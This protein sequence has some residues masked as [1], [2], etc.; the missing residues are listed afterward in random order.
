MVIP[1]LGYYLN[2]TLSLEMKSVGYVLA[3]TSLLGFS[4]S[5]YGGHF[6]DKY[7]YKNSMILAHMIRF[8]SFLLIAI[9]IEVKFLVVFLLIL[10]TLGN[11]FY[12]PAS[13]GY[14]AR[15]LQNEDKALFFS[16][17]KSAINFGT[18]FGPL[19]SAYFIFNHT[20]IIFYMASII[21]CISSIGHFIMLKKDD[22]TKMLL[23]SFSIKN[24][25]ILISPSNIKY[26]LIVHFL[27]F[28]IFFFF[29]HYM[30]VFA[31]EHYSTMKYSTLIIF[32]SL[33]IVIFQPLLSKSIDR[34]AYKTIIKIS[35][36]FFAIGMLLFSFN[37]YTLFIGVIFFSF[38]EMLIFLKNELEII[39][40]NDNVASYIGLLRFF[41]GIGAATSG[42]VGGYMYESI[43]DI[44]SANFFWIMIS[45][46]SILSLIAL[47][48]LDNV[49]HK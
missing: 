43:N 11:V 2:S 9:F 46:L 15:F 44:F 27:S 8:V 4:G 24:I 7:G 47:L 17:Q 1:F 19:L 13:Q 20:D 16:L 33:L 31:I 10:S 41:M 3:A 12:M 26:I 18:I 36:V 30:S 14:L 40:N 49:F 34:Y 25:F 35:F 48:K 39:K 5:L 42:L 37:I 21:F 29:Q 22:K 32:S 6:A 23:H 45:I 28:F 38:A